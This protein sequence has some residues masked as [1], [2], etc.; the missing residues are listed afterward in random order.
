MHLGRALKYGLVLVLLVGTFP[1]TYYLMGT[2]LENSWRYGL[3][4]AAAEGLVFGRDVGFTYGPLVYLMSPLDLGRNYAAAMLLRAVLHILF[5]LA[6]VLLAR[7]PGGVAVF[8]ASCA[9]YLLAVFAGLA[10]EYH[11]VVL[12]CLWLAIA[13]RNGRLALPVVVLGAFGAVACLLMKF[14]MG[15]AAGAAVALFVLIALLREPARGVRLLAAAALGLAASLLILVP[16]VFRSPGPFA[17]WLRWSVELSSGY[18][19]AMSRT[20]WMDARVLGLAAL[21]AYAVITF[22]LA[23]RKSGAGDLLLVSAGAVLLAF[24]HGFTR[25][26]PEHFMMYFSFLLA[27]LALAWL[28]VRDRSDGFAL[29]L[30]FAV[31]LAATLH[32][33]STY[34]AGDNFRL[35]APEPG[36]YGPANLAFLRHPGRA[37]AERQARSRELLAPDVLPRELV[38]E[39]EANGWTVDAVT[40]E[41]SLVAANGLAWKPSPLMH[42]YAYF[43]PRLDGWAAAH[44]DRAGADVLLVRPD[45]IDR[46]YALWDTPRT[47]RAILR[48]YRYHAVVP[49]QGLTVLVRRSE[50]LQEE[51]REA[52]SA[53]AGRDEWVE[54]PPSGKPLWAEVDLRLSPRGRIAKALFRIPPVDLRVDYED[55][56]RATYRVI[57]DLMR[58]GLLVGCIPDPAAFSEFL[59]DFACRRVV[60]F[61]LWGEGLKYYGPVMYIT[62][63]ETAWLGGSGG[64]GGV[65]TS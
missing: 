40:W 31:V 65:P 16:V 24:K 27:L 35:R 15:L 52:G 36:R 4:A 42:F 11:W 33:K 2:G 10:D 25:Q 59:R 64:S 48:N 13:L 38:G 39:I 50:P 3:N 20:G 49:E 18:S 19:V 41:T 51:W 23:K 37:R 47:W 8:A 62:W 29:A 9:G 5:A 21:L 7:S 54:V 30:A 45:T 6:L 28:F 17:T 44:Y 34:G 57:P 56:R 26:D 1:C 32:L 60:R 43:T 63:R 14:S 22:L 12:L 46:R 58:N 55:G 61:Q 53:E